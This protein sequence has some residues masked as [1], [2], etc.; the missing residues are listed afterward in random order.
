MWPAL[1]ALIT[2]QLDGFIGQ[3]GNRQSVG[4]PIP[5]RVVVQQA[6]QFGGLGLLIGALIL[7]SVQGNYDIPTFLAGA[8][9][10]P[11]ELL[12]WKNAT[13]A[14]FEH[15]QCVGGHFFIQDKAEEFTACLR[16]VISTIM[17]EPDED[18][19]AF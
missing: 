8:N 10:F 11:A 16:S 12:A 19:V 15:R 1:R 9:K 14:R 7:F 13:R 18:L 2:A 5:Q 6:R 3:I 17:Q 4:A